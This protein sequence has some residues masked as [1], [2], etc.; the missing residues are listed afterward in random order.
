MDIKSLTEGVISELIASA[1]IEIV[2]LI[3]RKGQDALK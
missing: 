2:A 3:G 1:L